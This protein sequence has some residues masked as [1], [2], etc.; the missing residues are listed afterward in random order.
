LDELLQPWERDDETRMLKVQSVSIMGKA[1]ILPGEKGDI[2]LA[3]AHVLEGQAHNYIVEN[4]LGRE[5]FDDTV[6]VYTGPII[7]VLG[8]SLQNRDIL[9]MFHS[10]SWKAVGL[11]M[12]GGRNFN[13]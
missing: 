3:T 1:G 9:E 5:D 8:T 6:N 12:E 10:T 7:T 4:D 13:R 11:E 2:M